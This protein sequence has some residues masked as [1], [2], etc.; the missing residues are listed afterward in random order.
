MAQ[1]FPTILLFLVGFAVFWIIAHASDWTSSASAASEL[2]DRT[3][4]A[5]E[6]SHDPD[7][8]QEAAQLR[9]DEAALIDD[10]SGLEDDEAMLEAE[11]ADLESAASA[12]L[13]FNEEVK[14]QTSQAAS[15]LKQA[16]L[17]DPEDMAEAGR[18]AAKIATNI[19]VLTDKYEPYQLC[20]ECA[21]ILDDCEDN[22]EDYKQTLED[23]ERVAQQEEE[24]LEALV[25]SA[26][27]DQAAH[28]DDD[29]IAEADREKALKQ[30]K[31]VEKA[32]AAIEE[33]ARQ[34]AQ[35]AEDLL[36][37]VE[38]AQ[39]SISNLLSMYEEHAGVVETI[40]AE[41]STGLDNAELDDAVSED[42]SDLQG[43]ARTVLGYVYP[44][45][46]LNKL[47][48]AA[49]IGKRPLMELWK[50]MNNEHV[51]V[52]KAIKTLEQDTA[53]IEQLTQQIEEQH[54]TT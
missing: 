37:T 42:S 13:S 11:E 22:L 5:A 3:I 46:M 19:D 54:R 48:N 16:N 9:G 47:S 39:E 27:E 17:A 29:D 40:E 12:L 31:K 23:I 26:R 44:S 35:R 49:S 18:A 38:E 14:K 15:I 41:R 34:A 45:T 2:R 24:D 51:A 53:R 6:M 52:S 32:D 25:E 28:R 50:D 20:E 30:G 4:R 7:E 21:S 10:I 43:A 33:E 36:S 1:L 8:E